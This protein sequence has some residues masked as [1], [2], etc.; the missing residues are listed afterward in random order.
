[1]MHLVS[2]PLLRCSLLAVVLASL[3]IPA[4]AQ[5]ATGWDASGV[6]VIEQQGQQFNIQ[7]TLQ[8]RG[9]VITGTALHVVNRADGGVATNQ[10][11]V[12]GTLDGDSFNVQIF[13]TSRQ[14]GVYIAKV[15]PSGRLDGEGYE[16]NTPS[17][18]PAW[19][20]Q[21]VLKCTPA[22][23]PAPRPLRSTG[24]ARPEAQSSTPAAPTPPFIV[25][26]SPLVLQPALPYAIVRLAWDGGPDHPNVE[27]FL[28]VNNGPETPAYSMD[29]PPQHPLFKQPKAAFEM[30]VERGG[31]AYKYVL[32][33][34]GKTLATAAFAVP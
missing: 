4:R 23:P 17:V 18:R 6:H 19:H 25:A 15:L 5:C 26:S 24:K 34:A 8:Q 10:G 14:T 33:A 2:G 12:D 9:R 27:V 30:K 11:T 16:K 29:F 7:L 13:W 32:K 22:A 28:S 3:P 21:G 31:K 1:M 20:S